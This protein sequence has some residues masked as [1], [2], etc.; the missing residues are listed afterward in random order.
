M[1]SLNKVHLMGYLCADP[2]LKQTPNG[3]HV[4]TFRIGVARRRKDADG[5]TISDFF[6]VVAWQS[7][8]EFVAKYF[9]KGTAVIISGALQSRSYTD[10]HGDKRYVVEVIADEVSFGESKGN[11]GAEQYAPAPGDGDVPPAY[12]GQTPSFAPLD[13]NEDLPY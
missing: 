1:A 10:A 8:A 13:T 3:T 11:S 5:N 6:T 2:E 9:R 7:T 4:C 12:G